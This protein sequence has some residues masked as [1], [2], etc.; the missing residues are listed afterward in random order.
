MGYPPRD[1]DTPSH[2]ILTKP[3]DKG[4]LSNNNAR[5]KLP[6]SEGLK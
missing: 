6:N 3:F 2:G 1:T 4:S 5:R